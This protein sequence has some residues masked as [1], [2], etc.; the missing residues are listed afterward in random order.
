MPS[1]ARVAD[2]TKAILK[3]ELDGPQAEGVVRTCQLA[4]GP[5]TEALTRFDRGGHAL[6]YAIRSGLPGMVKGPRTRG[7]SRRWATGGPARP[8]P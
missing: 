8:A 6:T 2:W 1:S 4:S 3:S 7:R 5:I